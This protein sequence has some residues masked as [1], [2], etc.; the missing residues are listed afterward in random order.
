VGYKYDPQ[1][2]QDFSVQ[3]SYA[4]PTLKNTKKKKRCLIELKLFSL[5]LPAPQ[6]FFMIVTVDYSIANQSMILR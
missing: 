3:K 2:A 5:K 4:P 1:V 6:Q